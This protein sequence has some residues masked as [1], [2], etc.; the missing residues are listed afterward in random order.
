MKRIG[1]TLVAVLAASVVAG[2]PALAA[3]R[4]MVPCKTIKAAIDSGKSADDV[5]KDLKVSAKRVKDCT[6][7]APAHKRSSK[8]S[9]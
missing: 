7:P 3:K 4:H 9:S 8:K 2:A 6:T 5:A 1:L